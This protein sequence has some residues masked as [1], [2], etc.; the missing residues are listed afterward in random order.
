MTFLDMKELETDR[1]ILRKISKSD[2]KDMYEYAKNPDVSKY[3]TWSAHE[4]LRYTRSYIKFLIKKYREGEYF[5]WAIEEKESHKFIGTCGYSMFDEENF[6]VEV[7]YVLNPDFCKR[8]Y[9]TEAVK[10][11]VE[12]AKELGMHRVEARIIKENTV[13]ENVIKKCGFILEGIGHDEMYIKGE[14]KTILH[15]ARLI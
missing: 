11:I 12:Y 4:S 14:Y 3:L 7:G 8:G 13:S 1:L 5:D 15:Y 9:A 10:R 6:K 2:A